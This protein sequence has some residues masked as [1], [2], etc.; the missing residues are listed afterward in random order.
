[1]IGDWCLVVQGRFT[2]SASVGVVGKWKGSDPSTRSFHLE[3]FLLVPVIIYTV[4]GQVGQGWAHASVGK[5]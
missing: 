4:N 2:H 1:M 5:E 3:R